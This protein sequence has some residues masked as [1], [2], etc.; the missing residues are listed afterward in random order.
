MANLTMKGLLKKSKSSKPSELLKNTRELL[1]FLN[2]DKDVRE[3]KCKE[4]VRLFAWFYDIADTVSI[5][6]MI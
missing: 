2:A 4:K 6:I 5:S 1:I 3:Q